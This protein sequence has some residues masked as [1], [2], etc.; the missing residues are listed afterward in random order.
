MAMQEQGS[1]TD[2]WVNGWQ[3]LRRMRLSDPKT[4]AFLTANI[5]DSVLTYMAL[6]HGSQLTE[7]NSILY[8]V[9]DKIGIGT[10]LFFKV[11]LC[12]GILWVLRMTN[13]EKLLVPLAVVFIAVALANLL[14]ARAHG[15][16]V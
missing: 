16:E 10:T 8:A 4:D 2:R 6:Q 1:R 7:F 11:V 15:I 12:V 9:M 3:I 13:K 5:M 14:V